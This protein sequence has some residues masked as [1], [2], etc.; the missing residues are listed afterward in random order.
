MI[1]EMKKG[2]HNIKINQ[3]IDSYNREVE[4]YIVAYLDILGATNRIKENKDAQNDSLI[5]LYNLYKRTIDLA[6]GNGIKNF[7]DIK[8]KIFVCIG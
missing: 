8:F 5:F 4:P 2:K 3:A 6:A 1:K 7:L